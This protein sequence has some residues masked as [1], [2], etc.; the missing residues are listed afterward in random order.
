MRG[1]TLVELLVVLVIAAILAALVYPNYRDFVRRANRA[2]GDTLINEIMQA[3]VRYFTDEVTYTAN[4]TELGYDTS[5]DVETD[6][7]HY[8][9]SAAPCGGSTIAQCVV[10]TAEA[11]GSQTDDGDLS[12]DSRGTT[13]GNW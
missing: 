7:G 12:L 6:E 1:F 10:V 9:V 2:D 8:L 13:T 4:L 5:D 11:Q 3:Q